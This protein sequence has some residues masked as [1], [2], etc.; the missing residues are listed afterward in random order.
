M[1]QRQIKE[2]SRWERIVAE[3]DLL[4][5]ITASFVILGLMTSYL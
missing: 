1:N 3:R 5:V 2:Q 4:S